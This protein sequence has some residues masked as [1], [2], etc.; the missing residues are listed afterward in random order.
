[1]RRLADRFGTLTS[2]LALT[3]AC[4]CGEGGEVA[5]E[6][7]PA[8]EARPSE[9]LARIGD[10]PHPTA[11]IA[12]AGMGEIRIELL[13]EIAPE[14]VANFEEL[15][16]RGFYDGTTFHRVIP[17]FMIQGGDPISRGPDP[18]QLGKGGPGY[19]I[20]DEFTDYPHLRGTVSMANKGFP[21]TGGSQ[22]FIVHQ[23]ARNLDGHYTA[24]GRVSDGM[25]TVDAITEVEIDK[26][27]RYGPKNRP[28][29]QDVRIESVR[30]EGME[31]AETVDIGGGGDWGEAAEPGGAGAGAAGGGGSAPE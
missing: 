26:Y 13:P 1:M 5:G 31:E 20:P 9:A 14:T 28:Y 10:G 2:A 8:E 15:A 25:A 18:R 3:L 4:A 22:F 19:T 7:A 30:M 27:G 6:P 29:P 11:V 16:G 17:G 23:D 21:N 24:F 12:V